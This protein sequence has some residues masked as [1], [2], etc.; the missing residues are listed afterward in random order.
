MIAILDDEDVRINTFIA[1]FGSNNCWHSKNPH[2]FIAWCIEH[3]PAEITL[4]HDL[5]FF[6]YVGEP[7]FPNEVTGLDVAR[8]LAPEL[9]STTRVYIH[10]WNVSGAGRM[11][12][13]FR[14]HGFK[15]KLAPFSSWK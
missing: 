13:I 11:A 8:A 5:Q 3:K 14:D 9:P 10:S 15:V 2:E 7:P 4:D 12:A 6:D 1:R